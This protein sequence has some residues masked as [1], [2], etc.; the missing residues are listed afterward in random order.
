MNTAPSLDSCIANNAAKWLTRT[1]EHGNLEISDTSDYILSRVQAVHD[2]LAPIQVEPLIRAVT[3]FAM[4]NSGSPIVAEALTSLL[5]VVKLNDAVNYFDRE[6]GI[7][8]S[9]IEDYLEAK[10]AEADEPNHPIN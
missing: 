4:H 7:F 3:F 6:I 9:G 10:R 1:D 2:A 8:E 5:G